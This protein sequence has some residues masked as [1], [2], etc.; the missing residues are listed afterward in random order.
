VLVLH[1]TATLSVSALLG[2][3]V[4]A[5]G[6]GGS[7][8]APAPGASPAAGSS[9]PAAAAGP[10]AGSAGTEK[11]V[12]VESNPPGDISDNIQYVAYTNPAGRYT[13]KHPEG[14]VQQEQGAS[15]SF[16]D[17]LNGLTVGPGTA[18]T[19]PTVQTATSTDVPAL[20]RS[21]PAFQLGAVSAVTV[22]AGNGVRIVYRRNSAPDPVTG[23]KYRDEVQRYELVHNGREVVVELFGPVGSDNVD[24]Y[25]IMI[26]SLQIS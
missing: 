10:S 19:A 22:P 24:P 4:L 26:Q 8:P 17:K 25:R 13:I 21:Q 18:T 11:P 12:A 5:T 23:R 2:V 7:S 15:A 14:W 3:A 9:A 1:R 20:Q 6:C 16:N